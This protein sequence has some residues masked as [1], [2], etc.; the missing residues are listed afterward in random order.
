[1]IDLS[2]TLNM[3]IAGKVK[4]SNLH[5]NYFIKNNYQPYKSIAVMRKKGG[6]ET[7]K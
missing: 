3:L 1:M 5:K 4:F 6:I 7:N 2:I